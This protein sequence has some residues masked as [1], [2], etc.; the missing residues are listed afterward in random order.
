MPEIYINGRS[1]CHN[2]F[3][4]I[5]GFGTSIVTN[6]GLSVMAESY[7]STTAINTPTSTLDYDSSVCGMNSSTDCGFFLFCVGHYDCSCNLPRQTKTNNWMETR[8]QTFISNGVSIS[9]QSNSILTNAIILSILKQFTIFKCKCWIY[10]SKESFFLKK[11]FCIDLWSYVL[12]W[13][14]TLIYPFFLTI[15]WVML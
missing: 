4:E 5:D 9:S 12:K 8:I 14:L 6:S 15:I 13:G 10:M 3:L 7:N 2:S 1:L 11:Q